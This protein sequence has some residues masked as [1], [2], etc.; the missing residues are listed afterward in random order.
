MYRLAKP[1]GEGIRKILIGLRTLASRVPMTYNNCQANVRSLTQK[2][3]IDDLGPGPRRNDGRLYVVY[4]YEEINRRRRVAGL[5]HIL[6]TTRA[7]QLVNPGAPNTGAPLFNGG[8]PNPGASDLNPGAP[9]LGNP[10]A[11]NKGALLKNKEIG[12]KEPPPAPEKLITCLQQQIG[13]ADDRLIAKMK[14]Q[15]AAVAP[16]PPDDD[17]LIAAITAVSSAI[18]R[19]PA[20]NSPTA[21]LP[22][23]IGWFFEG[24]TGK[25]YFAEK[26]ARLEAEKQRDL[27]AA[28]AI[29]EHPEEWDQDSISWATALL[30]TLS[31]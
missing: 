27:R 7:V 3:A 15:A 30:Q 9:K 10:G 21:V 11:P 23:R 5:T 28:R 1:A 19:D 22:I 24:E 2:L 26:R 4:D 29:L 14:E 17:D 13:I 31:P 16:E 25:R 8:A 12:G 6:R 18:R 20:I